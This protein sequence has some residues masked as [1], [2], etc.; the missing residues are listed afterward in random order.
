ME[1]RIGEE[2]QMMVNLKDVFYACNVF[3]KMSIT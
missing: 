1:H 2:R 3:D